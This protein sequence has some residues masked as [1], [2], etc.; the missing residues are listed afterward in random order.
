VRQD[1][2]RQDAVRQ[3]VVRQ[4]AVRQ[5]AVRQDAGGRMHHAT[6]LRDGDLALLPCHLPTA[7]SYHGIS[8]TRSNASL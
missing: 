2:V 1:A 4:D 7:G 6:E 8:K 3:D 5:D